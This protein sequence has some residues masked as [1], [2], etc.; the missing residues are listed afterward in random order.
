MIEMIENGEVAPGAEAVAERAGVGLRTVFRQFENMEGLYQ[1][2][3]AAVAAELRPMLEAAYAARDWEG[4]LAEIIDRRVT[5]F[6]RIRPLKTAAE[7][8][9]HRSPFLEAQAARMVRE[10]RDGLIAALPHSAEPM[11]LESLD[12]ILS[13]EVWRR[14]RRDQSLSRTQARTVVERLAAAVIKGL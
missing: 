6:E 12:L 9:R 10:E 8:H 3:N 4:R 13:F 2:I 1:H 5:I 14:L 11:I 7:V